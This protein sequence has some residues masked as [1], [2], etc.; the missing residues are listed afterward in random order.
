MVVEFV[1]YPYLHAHPS[2]FVSVFDNDNNLLAVARNPAFFYLKQEEVL[3]VKKQQ[4]QEWEERMRD[5]K[6]G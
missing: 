2:F 3:E 1:K 6:L 5:K 4:D